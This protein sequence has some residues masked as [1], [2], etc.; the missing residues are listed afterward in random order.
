MQWKEITLKREDQCNFYCRMVG[1]GTPL[2]LIHGAA[3]DSEFFIETA[4]AFA[5][6][7]QAITYDRSGYGL[8]TR[9][10]IMEAES[11]AAYFGQQADDV[12]WVLQQLA[13]GQKAV[14]V[15]CSCG[16]AVAAYLA[17]R[18]PELIE[19]VFLH[20]PPIYS[21]MTEDKDCWDLINGIHEAFEQKKYNRALN[22]FLLF[23]A[24]S[25]APSKKPMTEAEMEKFATNGM[26]F[27]RQEFPF[28]FDRN[29][30]V[31]P[32]QP[33]TKIAV[34]WGADGAGKP[35]VECAGR[36]AQALNCP[37]HMIPGGHNAARENPEEFAQAVLDLLQ[38]K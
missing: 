15:G 12:A 26:A 35:L 17:A 3:V 33:E 24:S 1:K 20:E 5:H 19:Q 7:Y 4:P 36:V 34:L 2:L 37:L 10:N 16:A 22:R 23:L 8:S 31:P 29:F 25:S 18:H 13:P 38:G 9:E 14:V 6:S 30:P 27:I 21:L 28:A 32:V 11:S